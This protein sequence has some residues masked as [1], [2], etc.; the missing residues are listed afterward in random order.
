MASQATPAGAE[1]LQ[2]VERL[3][4]E[5]RS[6]REIAER[7]GFQQAAPALAPGVRVRKLALN[8]VPMQPQSRKRPHERDRA[9]GAG[10]HIVSVGFS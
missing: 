6:K 8:R 2:E 9:G 7:M 3:A 1:L 10:S 5:G 4:A